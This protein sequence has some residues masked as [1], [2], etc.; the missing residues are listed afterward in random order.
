M[1]VTVKMKCWDGNKSWFETKMFQG[2]DL[3]IIEEQIYESQDWANG[4]CVEDYEVL[5]AAE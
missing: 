5:E 2:E 1:K 3:Y 4:S